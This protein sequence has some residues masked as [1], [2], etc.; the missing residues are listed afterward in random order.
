M[1]GGGLTPHLGQTKYDFRAVNKLV[2][3]AR[4]IFESQF[5]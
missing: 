4:A 2:C 5:L 1:G 3:C